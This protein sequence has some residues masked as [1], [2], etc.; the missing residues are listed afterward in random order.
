MPA[1][2]DFNDWMDDDE[3]LLHDHELTDYAL[4]EPYLL[5]DIPFVPSDEKIIQAMLDLAALERRDLLYDLGCGDG[6]IVVA[7]A[8]QKGA[9]AIG[10]DLDPLRIAEAMEYAGNV[11]V[12]HLVDFLEGDLLEADFSAATVVCL[13]LLD[14]I[15]LQLRPRLQQELR[16]GS[17][18]ISHTFGMGD[19]EPDAHVRIDGNNV[20][21]WIVP[22]RVAGNWQWEDEH[23]RAYQLELEQKH[24]MLGGRIRIDGHETTL[25]ESRIDGDLLE[26][27]WRPSET[28][29][30]SCL[31]MRHED[32]RLISPGTGA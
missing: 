27:R 28:G 6:R 10:I 21:K 7:A 1:N 17:R 19:W 9:R 2:D 31:R 5:L 25:V 11:R 18:I 23:G 20:Y 22:A 29:A 13:Y 12:E 4:D 14:S 30:L 3:Y 26:L 16:P 32:G 24:Q 15:N 8:R